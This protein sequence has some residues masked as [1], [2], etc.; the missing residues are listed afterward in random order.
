[1]LQ[2]GAKL[3]IQLRRN[4]STKT[5]QGEE[6]ASSLANKAAEAVPTMPSQREKASIHKSDSNM[7]AQTG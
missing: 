2:N 4:H 1:M 5:S 7:R 3:R 6:E